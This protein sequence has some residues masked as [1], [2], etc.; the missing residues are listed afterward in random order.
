MSYTDGIDGAFICFLREFKKITPMN[1]ETK[2]IHQLA[3]DLIHELQPYHVYYC[4]E[5]GKHV[6]PSDIRYWQG[7][8][9]PKR[10]KPIK[11]SLLSRIIDKQS[12]E[13]K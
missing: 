11:K 1:E 9:Q 8:R 12:D 3:D 6:S 4:E 13:V 10:E 7:Y 5:Y 2:D